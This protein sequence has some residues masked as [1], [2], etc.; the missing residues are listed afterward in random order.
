MFSSQG[1]IRHI[2]NADKLDSLVVFQ[3]RFNTRYNT[4]ISVN[5]STDP[6]MQATATRIGK[7]WHAENPL[8]RQG[9]LVFYGDLLSVLDLREVIAVQ[10]HELGHF[11]YAM[12]PDRDAQVAETRQ[13]LR[14]IGYDENAV[15]WLEN[16]EEVFADLYAVKDLSEKYGSESDNYIQN[17]LIRSLALDYENSF[18]L[19]QDM[20]NQDN[21]V[22]ILDYFAQQKR[23]V[24]LGQFD[25]PP[26]LVRMDMVS[27]AHRHY[28]KK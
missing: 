13:I 22:N 12:L 4:S 1:R 20:L 5:V 10:S 19:Q 15:K 18:L 17:T 3:D 11:K 24:Q 7:E 23:D 9:E 26:P 8:G 14:D 25:Y 16:S 6:G 28:M 2:Y 21:R 27:R